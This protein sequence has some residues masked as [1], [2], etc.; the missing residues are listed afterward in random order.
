MNMT[1]LRKI[2][3]VAFLALLGAALGCADLSVE[4]PNAPDRSRALATPGDV[5]SLI[6]GAYHTWWNTAGGMYSSSTFFL[7]AASFQH[8]SWP[9]N[10]G[11]VFYSAFPR[12]PIANNPANEYYSNMADPYEES[13]SALSAVRSGLQSINNDEELASGLQDPDTPGDEVTR[14]RAFGKFMQGLG[15]ATVALVYDQGFILDEN[16]PDADVQGGELQPVAYD[17]LMSAAMGYFDQAISLSE[18]ADFTIPSSWM[19]REVSASELAEL[20]HS[21]KA[22]YMAAVARTPAEREAVDWQAVLQEAN[23]GVSSFDMELTGMFDYS[24]WTSDVVGYWT[25]A[26]WQQLTYFIHGM[27]DQSGDYQAWLGQ[28]IG[29]RTPDVN[30]DPVLIQTPDTRFPQGS[31]LEDQIANPGEYFHVPDPDAP[32]ANFALANNFQNPGR[33]TWRW[34]YYFD[35]RPRLNYGPGPWPMITADEMRLLRAEAHL[36]MDNYGDAADLINETRTAHGLNET[37][38]SGTN[39]SCVP[40]L[41]SGQCASGSAVGEERA[42]MEMLKWEKRL[43]TQYRGLLGVP[44]YFE[45]RGWGDLYAGTP[46]HFP[47]PAE[48]AALLGVQEYTTGGCGQ[49]GGAE[50]SVYQWPDQCGLSN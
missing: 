27:A 7:S 25:F 35:V 2:T 17:S 3:S 15:H 29:N 21:L 19:S 34:S 6:S 38:A 26:G 10:A 12:T 22:R 33:G 44:W 20:S 41:P 23:A 43:E 37:D 42:L 49:E 5:E 47:L 4:N 30:G 39:S 9:A 45:G 40:K 16:V 24:N 46:V 18:G 36:R 8:S 32:V 11:A 14:A 50:P 13:Y 1:K 31:T 28:S 48:D